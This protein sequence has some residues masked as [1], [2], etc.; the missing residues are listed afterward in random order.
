MLK[1]LLRRLSELERRVP[2]MR[3]KVAEAVV[4]AGEL[5]V[6]VATSPDFLRVVGPRAR[7]RNWLG[8]VPKGR[9]VLIL[10]LGPSVSFVVLIEGRKPC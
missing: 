6:R 1:H 10:T 4:R 9:D 5:R 8:L 7:K 3:G 2:C